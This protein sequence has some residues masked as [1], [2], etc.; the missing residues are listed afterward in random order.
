MSVYLSVFVASV[1]LVIALGVG[2]ACISCVCSRRTLVSAVNYCST[3]GVV[4]LL[5]VLFKYDSCYQ[6]FCIRRINIHIVIMSLRSGKSIVSTNRQKDS[7]S[8]VVA[9]YK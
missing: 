1:I 2:P 5:A 4:V 6:H 8:E 7:D 3:L 9:D